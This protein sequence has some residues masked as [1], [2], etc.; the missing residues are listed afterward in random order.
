MLTMNDDI[1]DNHH[2]NAVDISI[3]AA[4]LLELC[5]EFSEFNSYCAFLCD[6]FSCLAGKNEPVEKNRAAGVALFT[7]WMKYRMQLLQI[8]LNDIQ[9]QLDKS[10]TAAKIRPIK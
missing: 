3:I 7:D 8:E 10:V 1:N 4:S 6:S 2:K 9:K 5:D